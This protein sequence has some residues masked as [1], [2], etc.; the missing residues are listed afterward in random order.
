MSFM[1][2]AAIALLSTASAAGA[3]AE[4]PEPATHTLLETSSAQPG[5]G[6]AR[7]AGEATTPAPASRCCPEQP[8]R[9]SNTASVE[10]RP[11]TPGG[12]GVWSAAP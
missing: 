7:E 6:S 10:G 4:K 8:A 3:P 5:G 1:S 9:T 12:E 11:S 2:F